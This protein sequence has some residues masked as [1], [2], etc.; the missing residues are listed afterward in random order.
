MG[1]KGGGEGA[2]GTGG[3]DV[4]KTP[5]DWLQKRICYEM[6]FSKVKKKAP[7]TCWGAALLLPF[8]AINQI[9]RPPQANQYA[10]A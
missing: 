5:N 1:R 4:Y 2:T 6:I 8:R 9:Q 3:D 10:L 7:P